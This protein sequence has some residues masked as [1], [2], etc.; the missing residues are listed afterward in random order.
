MTPGSPTPWETG[1]VGINKAMRELNQ[2]LPIL[3]QGLNIQPGMPLGLGGAV[4]QSVNSSVQVIGN[5]I[6]RGD[7]TPDSLGAALQGQRY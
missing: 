7:T 6:I 4:D 1:L 5:V 3:A 2:Q